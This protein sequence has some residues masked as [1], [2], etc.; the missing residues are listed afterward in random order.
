MKKEPVVDVFEPI[1]DETLITALSPPPKNGLF[2]HCSI[3]DTKLLNRSAPLPCSKV[4]LDIVKSTP[5]R[6]SELNAT[7]IKK[8]NKLKTGISFSGIEELFLINL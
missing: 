1:T 4:A 2:V 5:E 3:H 6:I 7:M 8:T